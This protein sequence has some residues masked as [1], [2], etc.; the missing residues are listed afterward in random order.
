MKGI[1]NRQKIVVKA[2]EAR[3]KYR[4]I[5]VNGKQK[6]DKPIIKKVEPS[7]TVKK[8]QQHVFKR[9]KKYEK[10]TFLEQFAMF[11]GSAQIL[12]AGLKQLLARRNG[13]DIDELEKWTLGGIT[14]ALKDCSIRNDFVVLMENIVKHRN[15]IAHE[16][17]VNEATLKAIVGDSG[18]LEKRHL[19]KGI[20]ELEQV[21]FLY[22]WCEEHDAWG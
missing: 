9:L 8:I 14:R 15:Y 20:Y 2:H 13:Y 11:I 17:L 10:L 3:R 7:L 6:N 12:E 1:S 18:A 4:H 19:Y 22:D 21:M 16:L 5:I